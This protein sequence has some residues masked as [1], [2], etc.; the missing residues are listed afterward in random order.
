[1]DTRWFF[2]AC[3]IGRMEVWVA[4]GRIAMLNGS[5][6]SA[7]RSIPCT[8][9]SV[10][11]GCVNLWFTAGTKFVS[12][13]IC[14]LTTCSNACG[15]SSLRTLVL[16]HVVLGA[17]SA[18]RTENQNRRRG[19]VGENAYY[20]ITY[21]AKGSAQRRKLEDQW[22]GWGYRIRLL[23]GHT[24]ARGSKSLLRLGLRGG[25]TSLTISSRILRST[26]AAIAY[27]R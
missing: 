19:H 23:L 12:V 10:A 4:N 24:I 17:A 1:M 14:G 13:F 8:F 27:G 16:N 2:V 26:I 25:L 21:R 3:T 18:L 15:V 11:P 6:A 7:E 5:R 20:R 22:R 9:P